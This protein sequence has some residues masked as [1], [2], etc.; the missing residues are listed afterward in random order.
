MAARWGLRDSHERCLSTLAEPREPLR[1]ETTPQPA[2]TAR[3]AQLTPSIRLTLDAHDS[4][5][6]TTYEAV[7]LLKQRQLPSE[8]R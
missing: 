5:W 8:A 2:E 3:S 6:N 1:P 7:Q 4:A